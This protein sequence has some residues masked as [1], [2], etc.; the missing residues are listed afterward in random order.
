MPNSDYAALYA[1]RITHVNVADTRHV[2]ELFR[3]P[4]L[5][6]SLSESSCGTYG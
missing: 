5:A 6:S 3:Q 4:T 1:A 2:V